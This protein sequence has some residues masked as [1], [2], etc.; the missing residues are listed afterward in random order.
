LSVSH[1]SGWVEAPFVTTAF[2]E[3]SGFGMLV[4]GAAAA[5]L[6]SLGWLRV[7]LPMGFVWLDFP[8]GAQLNQTVLGNLELGLEHRSEVA[9]STRVE[10]VA[11]LIAPSAERGPKTALLGNRA[12]ALASALNGG[13]DSPL[14]TPGV[15]GARL[16]ASLERWQGPFGF[17]ASLDL[18]LLVRLSEADLPEDTAT[19]RLGILPA[20]DLSAAWWVTSR[21]GVSLAG[22][23][24]TEPL[25]VQEPSL[26]RDRRQ[27][28]QAVVEPGL[29]LRLGQRVALGA[30][31][32]AAVGGNLGGDAWSIDLH[33]RLGF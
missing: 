10:L 4:T 27:R 15:S 23:L 30:S 28:L 33:G 3:V 12:L 19:H 6:P 21:F 32:S 26:D 7:R 1:R 22:A 29:H 20:I 13:K 11:A 31:A 9:P 14:W 2:P 24:I 25:R 5:Q 17:R 8:A 18:P 16:R